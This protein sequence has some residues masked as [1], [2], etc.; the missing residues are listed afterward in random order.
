MVRDFMKSSSGLYFSRLDHIRALAAYLVFVWHFTH[1][2]T[3][4]PVPFSTVPPFPFALVQEGHVG[5]GLFMTLSGYLFAKLVNG[6]AIN[7]P[8]F[9]WSRAVRLVPLLAGSL[10][11][12]YILSKL[13]V[14]SP[15][16]F[17]QIWRGVL[18]PTLPNGAWSITVEF[19]FYL[20]FP[21]LLALSNRFGPCALLI[22]ICLSLCLRAL[23]WVK[24]GEVQLVAYWTIVG[25]IDQ[26][27]MGMFF[28][29]AGLGVKARRILAFTCGLLFL[30]FWQIFD[31]KGGFFNLDGAYPSPSALWIIIPSA[32]AVAF[33]SF[34]AWYDNSGISVPPK[35]D[36]C[37]RKVGEWS[38]S[39]YLLHFFL[40]EV[41]IPLIED[42]A[43]QD[44]NF[45]WALPAASV[46]FAAFAPL[47]GLS[48]EFF[49][50]PLLRLRKAYIVRSK[51]GSAAPHTH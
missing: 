1:L 43:G 28:A 16:Y 4:F 5:V 12:W 9:L 50:K 3:Q 29:T 22:G 17:N 35:V 10:V 47:A 33:G 25:A 18:L 30:V 15:I 39:I 46:L 13:H 7:Y 36:L 51:T 6:Q 20:L 11:A 23:L 44:A 40:R 2:T 41:S 31:A 26:F 48:F 38:Y 37:L 34:V 24:Y 19:H 21:Y 42:R 14:G 27:L 8:A 32:Q 45:W 49:E